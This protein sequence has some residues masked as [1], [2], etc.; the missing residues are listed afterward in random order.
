M[1]R[2]SL[3]FRQ[4]AAIWDR[5]IGQEPRV[6]EMERTIRYALLPATIATL[7]LAFTQPCAAQ[8]FTLD[9][10]FDDRTVL[11]ADFFGQSVAMVYR[12]VDSWQ[13]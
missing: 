2:E 13:R 1:R 10:A 11:G 9:H 6:D 12:W 8:N 3:R 5:T 4:I 7:L